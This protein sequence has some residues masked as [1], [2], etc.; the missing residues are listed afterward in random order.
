MDKRI[1]KITNGLKGRITIPSDKSISHRAVIF[2]SL[3]N[4][5]SVI[6]NFSKGHDPLSTLEVCKNL[7]INYE[8]INNELHITSQGRLQTPENPLYCGNSGATVRLMGG[9][10]AGQEFEATLTGGQ[11]L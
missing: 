5:K 1:S 9:G 3:A 4:G 2:S 11:S 7:G 10:V 8:F 6:K